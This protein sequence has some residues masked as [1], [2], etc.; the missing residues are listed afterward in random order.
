MA[1]RAT[2]TIDTDGLSATYH[3]ASGGGDK[4]APGSGIAI[5][6]VNASGADVDVTLVTPGTVDGNPISDRVVTAPTMTSNTFI[7]VPE[8]YRNPAD[9][10]ASITWEATTS[11]TF[12]V[13]RIN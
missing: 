10:L 4:V 8:L 6:V 3:A 11:V 12:A 13:I 5:H 7:A 9:G 1:T 2:E